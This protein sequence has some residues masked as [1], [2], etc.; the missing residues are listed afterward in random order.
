MVPPLVPLAAGAV[1]PVLTLSLFARAADLP[2]VLLHS[3]ELKTR[4]ACFPCSSTWRQARFTST[5]MRAGWKE[6]NRNMTRKFWAKQR[7]QN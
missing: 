1:L 4:V 7:V 3:Y 6:D 2:K 5:G